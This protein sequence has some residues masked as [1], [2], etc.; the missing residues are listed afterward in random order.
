MIRKLMVWS[1]HTIQRLMYLSIYLKNF[2][3]L[4]CFIGNV[5]AGKRCTWKRLL[6]NVGIDE[7]EFLNKTIKIAKFIGKFKVHS[8]IETMDEKWLERRSE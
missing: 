8:S 7:L 5:I 2:T 4:F 1:T 3:K 6:I